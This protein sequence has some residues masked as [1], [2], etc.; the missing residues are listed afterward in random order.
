MIG[1]LSPTATIKD[2]A[3]YKIKSNSW[4]KL[5][6]L[7]DSRYGCETVVVGD[8]IYVFGGFVASN[9]GNTI[10]KQTHTEYLDIKQ[11]LL[12]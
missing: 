10:I 6:D 3:I 12:G 2:T 8:R 5:P 11:A 1:G 9:S 4:H 7:N